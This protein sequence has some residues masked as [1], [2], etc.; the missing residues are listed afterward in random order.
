MIDRQPID[1]LGVGAIAAPGASPLEISAAWWERKMLQPAPAAWSIPGYEDRPLGAIEEFD[2]ARYVKVRGM[3]PLSRAGQLGCVAAAAA[4]RFPEPLPFERD[5]V[6]VVLGTRWGSVEPLVEFDRS[7]AIDGPHLVN[8]AQFPNVVV[9]AHAGYIGLLFGLAGPNITLCG[10]GAGLEAIVQ[11]VDLLDLGRADAVLA[12][13]VEALGRTLLHGQA[14]CGAFERGDPPGEGAGMLLLSRQH[15]HLT[16]LARLVSWASLTACC[17]EELEDVRAL[18]LRNVLGDKRRDDVTTV[19]HA[20]GPTNAF[21]SI[22]IG[23]DRVRALGDITGD[24]EAATGAIAAALAVEQA[25]WGSGL[26][27]A[28]AFP[29]VGVQSAVLLA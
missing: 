4:L 7:A 17:A 12:G 27:L 8:P 3:R 19:W 14:R 16:P 25:A 24:C 26:V 29:A 15:T 10:G 18:V 23:S 5:D 28:T 11:A 6:G 20:G 2:P 1:V 9:N 21:R 22:G 13:G